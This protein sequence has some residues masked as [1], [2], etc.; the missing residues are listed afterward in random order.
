M[1]R[2]VHSER[3]EVLKARVRPEIESS[4]SINIQLHNLTHYLINFPLVIQG[5]TDYQTHS[6]S[7]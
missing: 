6:I 3:R 4:F 2:S 5:H 1:D 7:K